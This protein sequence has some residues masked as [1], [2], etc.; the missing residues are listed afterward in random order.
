MHRHTRSVSALI[1]GGIAATLVLAA[2]SGGSDSE[3]TDAAESLTLRVGTVPFATMAPF[4]I[5]RDE[6]RFEEAGLTIV[7]NLATSSAMHVPSLVANEIDIAYGSVVPVIQAVS[8]DFD[9][10]IFLINDIGGD[11]TDDTA[12][13]L[14][15]LP[16]G[17]TDPEDLRGAAI[18]I[19]AL[20]AGQQLTTTTSL[21]QHGLQPGDYELVEVPPSEQLQ[22]LETGQ[23]DAAWLADPFLTIGRVEFDAHQIV[24]SY[25]GETAG[26]PDGAW[27]TTPGYAAENPE[28]LELFIEVMSEVLR[29][30]AE[31]ED[32]AR[33][34]EI[35]PTFME[36]DEDL[37]AEFSR[38]NFDPNNSLDLVA[39]V[40]GLAL[41]YGLIE[42]E[43][44]PDSL[45]VGR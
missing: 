7:E 42:T 21:A 39:D 1:A 18:A 23:V 19:N 29:E 15:A 5:A 22:A 40:Y 8:R 41:E 14:Y 9:V 38:M 31:S 25:G 30:S 32:Q 43:I 17:V 20:G 27:I 44:D 12:S 36:V 10:Q 3:E 16:G 24:P 6:G 35:I 26:H 11:G 37:V 2:C 13:G 28:A 33:V 45:I 4:M 34:R